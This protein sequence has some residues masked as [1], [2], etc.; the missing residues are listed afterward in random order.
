MPA[1]TGFVELS[2]L[3]V[4]LPLA[5][6]NVAGQNRTGPK[7]LIVAGSESGSFFNSFRL[8]ERDWSA[9]SSIAP[10]ITQN[11]H[12]IGTSCA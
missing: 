2:V 4:R 9:S 7:V 6:I 5:D 8:L 12:L 1:A 11:P 3:A 10:W